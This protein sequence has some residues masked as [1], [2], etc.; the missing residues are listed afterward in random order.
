MDEKRTS[1]ASGGIGFFG[2]LT[3]VFIVLKLIGKISWSWILVLSPIWIGLVLLVLICVVP[4][5]VA[6]IISHK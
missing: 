6:V 5:L 1:S 3:L 4:I 2:L